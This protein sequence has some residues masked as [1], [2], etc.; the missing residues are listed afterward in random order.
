MN[1]PHDAESRL[2]YRRHVAWPSRIRREWPLIEKHLTT[3]PSER[4]LDLGCGTGEHARYIE[5]R[6]YDVVGIDRSSTQLA[7]A[8]EARAAAGRTGPRFVEGD[9]TAL[10]D[11]VKGRFGF[12]L[13][14][15]NTLPHLDTRARLDGFLAGLRRHL[16]PGGAFLVQML[17]YRRIFDRGVTA[18]PVDTRPEETRNEARNE[19]RG[20]A[21]VYL[22]L[23]EPLDA[24]RVRFTP[25]T[26]RY[27]GDG[28]PPLTMLRARSLT[29]RGWTAQEIDEALANSGFSFRERFGAMDE[30]PF[31][32]AR[33]LDL[34]VVAR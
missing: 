22:R 23:V 3:A 34:I 17:N 12:A 13:C 7:A 26:L 10:D 28:D 9:L 32:A 18:L 14:L 30:S 11:L 15:G 5:S 6:G 16:V 33:S 29:L 27:D 25:T 19:T 21:L 4:V 1:D 31:E 24:G 2:H 20:G 8:R